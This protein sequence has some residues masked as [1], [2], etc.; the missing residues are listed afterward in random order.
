MTLALA[1]YWRLRAAM[2]DL[3]RDQTAVALAQQRLAQSQQRRQ[4][5]WTEMAVKYELDV[6]GQFAM[7]DEDCSLTLAQ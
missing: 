1:D 5:V 4:Q 3:E 7:R 6:N 2:A